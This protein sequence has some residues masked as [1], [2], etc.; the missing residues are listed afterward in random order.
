MQIHA[1]PQSGLLRDLLTHCQTS[2][3]SPHPCHCGAP[4]LGGAHI[5]LQWR[6]PQWWA[7]GGRRNL[8]AAAARVWD[9]QSRVGNE[10]AE[11]TLWPE[12]SREEVVQCPTP[13]TERTGIYSQYCWSRHVLHSPGQRTTHPGHACWQLHH[14]RQLREAH[15]WVQ[16]KAKFPSSPHRPRAG[17]LAA[18]HQSH[19]WYQHGHNLI[20]PIN[21]HR[22]Y[23]FP[24]CA[25]WCKTIQHAHDP[26]CILFQGRLSLLAAGC[27][28]HAQSAILQGSWKPYV[29]FC[30]HPPRH[31][32]CSVNP[33]TVP[34]ES[35]GGALGSC[36]VH[37]P[38]SVWHTALCIDLW[39]RKT[40]SGGVHRCWRSLT[41]PPPSHL[42]PC[43]SHWWR[44][45]LMELMQTG[46]GH[47]VHCG[48][49]IHR[50][51][52]HSK[53]MHLAVPSHW[54]AVTLTTIHYY[55]ILWQPGH[56]E[57]GHRW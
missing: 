42:K 33:L 29:H 57:A 54:R 18:Q 28:T 16:S 2:Q 7:G 20:I 3:F 50:C 21:L 15:P 5:Q 52:A 47:I 17:A 30:C 44:C 45:I 32:F 56:P 11:S 27:C 38:V 22:L 35:G 26:I 19:L 10:T 43:I 48:G 6:I 1:D 37:L 4:W 23:H 51:D 36:E 25:D 49:R 55:I 41:G 31:N 13:H 12:A 9:R 53:R 46:V 14:D 8:H 40:W 24:L 34:W 39:G